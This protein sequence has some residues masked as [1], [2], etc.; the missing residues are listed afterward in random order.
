LFSPSAVQALAAQVDVT[1]SMLQQ[2]TV[3]G[4]IGHTTARAC[5]DIGL[6]VHVVPEKPD[7]AALV[8]AAAVEVGRW[9]HEP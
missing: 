5:R 9:R 1:S 6:S 7:A 8:L 2:E 4:C 3:V